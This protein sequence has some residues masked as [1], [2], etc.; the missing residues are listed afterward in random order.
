MLNFILLFAVLGCVNAPAEPE[1]IQEPKTDVTDS[2]SR[3]TRSLD[4]MIS[5]TEKMTK[6]MEIIM[7]NQDA[8]FRAVTKCISEETCDSLKDSMSH[9]D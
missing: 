6:N 8:I 1:D 7:E 2:L 4:S 3:S 5:T 9:S